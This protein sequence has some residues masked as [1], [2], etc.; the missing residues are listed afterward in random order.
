MKNRINTKEMLKGILVT[1]FL[2]FIVCSSVSAQNN[3]T[4]QNISYYKIKQIYV[5]PPQRPE[6]KYSLD[7]LRF[8][9]VTGVLPTYDG[10]QFQ[11]NLPQQK[12]TNEGESKGFMSD[13][14]TQLESPLTLDREM[15]LKINA[16]TAKADMG[17]INEK[18]KTGQDSTK[19]RLSGQFNKV[20]KSSISAA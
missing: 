19:K 2:F 3:N 8:K 7:Q 12:I 18:I 11:I 20:S 13:F 9:P 4:V 6:V 1:M 15:R 5:P 17:Y 10:E 14:L 16:T